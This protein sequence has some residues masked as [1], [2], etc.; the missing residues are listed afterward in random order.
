[1]E[2]GETLI[3]VFFPDV[4]AARINL[5]K[6]V[7]LRQIRLIRSKRRETNSNCNYRAEAESLKGLNTQLRILCIQPSSSLC[8]TAFPSS[9]SDS[10]VVSPDSGRVSVVVISSHEKSLLSVSG[11]VIEKRLRRSCRD[12]YV[13]AVRSAGI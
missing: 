3:K 2:V 10:S 9:S 12:L 4:A 5:I 8:W 7:S 1:M 13:F 6:M 11:F